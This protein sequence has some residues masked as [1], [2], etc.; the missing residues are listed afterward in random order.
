VAV[1]DQDRIIV[2]DSGNDRI[3]IFQANYPPTGQPEHFTVGGTV[4]G[5]VG[6]GLVLQNNGG[7]DLPIATNGEFTFATALADGSSYNVSV[8]SQPGDP[9]QTCSINNGSSTLAGADVRDVSVNCLLD[10]QFQINA[11]ISDAWFNPATTG[12]GFLIVLRMTPNAQL[13]MFQLFWAK[14]VITG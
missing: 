12:Q 7:D 3:Q 8:L 13:K 1:D 14:R 2:G 4:S 6:S 11:G 9:R 5:L 10:T